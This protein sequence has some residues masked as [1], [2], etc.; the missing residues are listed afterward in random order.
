MTYGPTAGAGRYA[1]LCEQLEQD[2]GARDMWKLLEYRIGFDE[3]LDIT[4]GRAFS[5][6]SRALLKAAPLSGCRELIPVIPLELPEQVSHGTHALYE[7][8]VATVHC[9]RQ[10]SPAPLQSLSSLL[11]KRFTWL[12][13]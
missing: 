10:L 13:H 3:S 7:V 6:N 12:P 11:G 1:D 5:L 4:V 2:P 8:D 9:R